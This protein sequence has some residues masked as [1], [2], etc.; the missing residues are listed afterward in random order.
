MVC[1][2]VLPW[3]GLLVVVSTD[4]FGTTGGV[5][6]TTFGSYGTPSSSLAIVRNKGWLPMQHWF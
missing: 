4:G 5:Q 6:S 3:P 1:N 2:F